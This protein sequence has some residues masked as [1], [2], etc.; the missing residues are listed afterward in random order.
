MLVV[1]LA[2]CGT[3]GDGGCPDP[4]L[5]GGD[6]FVADGTPGQYVVQ[7][8]Q[9]GTILTAGFVIGVAAP[10]PP[11]PGED[12]AFVAPARWLR[13]IIAAPGLATVQECYRGGTA[14]G[15]CAEL[16][17]PTHGRLVGYRDGIQTV[18]VVLWT[19]SAPVEPVIDGCPLLF[20]GHVD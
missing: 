1:V 6:F 16:G 20:A 10:T 19:P 17:P 9:D 18:D 2:A 8:E 5:A 14:A 11:L 4:A 7:A 15:A 3:D 13:L 12:F